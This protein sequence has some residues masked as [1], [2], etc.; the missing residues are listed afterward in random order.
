M[1][2]FCPDFLGVSYV[3]YY[4]HTMTNDN[5]TQYPDIMVYFAKQKSG[6]PPNQL[7]QTYGSDL[8][9]MDLCIIF[10]EVQFNND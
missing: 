7:R 3:T 2:I 8:H 6:V 5:A 9:T 4:R 10:P 1:C